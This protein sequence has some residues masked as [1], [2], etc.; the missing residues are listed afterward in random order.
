MV[1]GIKIKIIYVYERY[2]FGELVPEIGKFICVLSNLNY[3][4]N[5]IGSRDLVTD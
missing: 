1:V 5:D 4:S 3:Q 2:D